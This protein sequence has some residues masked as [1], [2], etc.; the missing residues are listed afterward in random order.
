[1]AKGMRNHIVGFILYHEALLSKLEVLGKYIA[2]GVTI[3]ES[4]GTLG[5]LKGVT[6]RWKVPSY[7]VQAIYTPS[8]PPHLRTTNPS[9]RCLGQRDLTCLSHLDWVIRAL[10]KLVGSSPRVPVSG[11][12]PLVQHD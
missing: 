6:R 1:M 8:V 10:F 7:C 11:F 9:T 2:K 4:Q 12:D 3:E 5:A